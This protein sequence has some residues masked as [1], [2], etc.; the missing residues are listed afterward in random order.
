MKSDNYKYLI[1][2]I[3]LDKTDDDG[4]LI[5]HSYCDEDQLK[6]IGVYTDES[7]EMFLNY[8]ENLH[9]VVVNLYSNAS[10]KN[11]R[12]DLDIMKLLGE[13]G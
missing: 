5:S 7:F 8:R 12:R 10:F 1:F 9:I 2:L 3:R 4:E 11:Y 6:S 13:L